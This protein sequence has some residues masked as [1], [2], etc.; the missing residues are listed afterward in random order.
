MLFTGVVVGV[1]YE[2][3]FFLRKIFV[4]NIFTIILDILFSLFSFILVLLSINYCAFGEI[5]LYLFL[6]LVLG[7]FIE[8]LSIG[9]LVAKTLNF[10]YTCVIVKLINKLK[11]LKGKQRGRKKVKKNC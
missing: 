5:R 1:F 8:R 4:L 2:V 10:I 11:Q 9:F 7:F 3:C 6:G